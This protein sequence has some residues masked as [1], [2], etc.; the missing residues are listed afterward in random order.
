[1]QEGVFFPNCGRC[2]ETRWELVLK[3]ELLAKLLEGDGR[4]IYS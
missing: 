2:F 3:D 1:M 4:K